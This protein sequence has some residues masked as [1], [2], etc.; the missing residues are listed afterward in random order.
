MQILGLAALFVAFAHT[1]YAYP[2]GDP[3]SPQGAF[4][5]FAD[6]SINGGNAFIFVCG[7][8]NTFQYSAG[9]R[10]PT[11]CQATLSGAFCT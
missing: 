6:P 9:C 2:I 11:C 5:C 4:G 10:C 1:A 7:P 3:C 8:T